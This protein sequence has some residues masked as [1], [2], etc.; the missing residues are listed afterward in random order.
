MGSAVANAV[1]FLPDFFSWDSN[2][3]CMIYPSSPGL[4]QLEWLCTT[5]PC[6]PSLPASLC[7]RI[8]ETLF[9]GGLGV[10]SYPAAASLPLWSHLFACLFSHILYISVIF[11]WCCSPVSL[12]NWKT[13]CFF[14]IFTLGNE[15]SEQECDLFNVN[16]DSSALVSNLYF[17]PKVSTFNKISLH[18]DFS[19]FLINEKPTLRGKLELACSLTGQCS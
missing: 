17:L 19:I 4:L 16:K 5:T 1:L 12:Q 6:K 11:V 7:I 14:L 8:S 2:S 13:I 9:S 10:S 18:F 15:G 3:L